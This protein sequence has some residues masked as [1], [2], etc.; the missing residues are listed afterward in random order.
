M[1]ENRVG[2]G[3]KR[4][5][6]DDEGMGGRLYWAEAERR[7][8][9]NRQRDGFPSAHVEDWACEWQNGRQGRARMTSNQPG[10][11][12]SLVSVEHRLQIVAVR[13]WIIRA[14]GRVGMAK[15]TLLA[16][17]DESGRAWMEE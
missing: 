12:I 6:D 16:S 17:V 11:R 8:C 10:R 15:L 9:V 1:E 2:E 4:Q 13:K 7:T 14:R 5:Q 3:K